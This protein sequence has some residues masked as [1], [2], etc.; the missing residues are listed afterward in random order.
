M[1]WKCEV[2]T[3]INADDDGAICDL[4]G[5]KKGAHDKDPKRRSS[6]KS[7]SSKHQSEKEKHMS[8]RAILRLGPDAFVKEGVFG[9]PLNSPCP[10]VLCDCMAFLRQNA[11]NHEGLFRVPGQQDLVEHLR[12]T[13]EQDDHADVL[14]KAKPEINDVATLLKL[15]FRTL[16]EPLIANESYANMLGAVRRHHG[17]KGEMVRAVAE[18]AMRLPS[19]NRELLGMLLDF[20]RDVAAYSQINKMTPANLAT[21]FAPSLLRAPEGH[22]PQEALMDMSSAIA[23]LNVLIK[24]PIH[25]PMPPAELIR[26]STTFRS[27]SRGPKPA[28]PPRGGAP[29][30]S[31]GGAVGPPPGMGFEARR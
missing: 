9:V 21:C 25:I 10:R 15:F 4:C 28:V 16:P 30:A 7:K 27:R 6:R 5:E 3:L 22:S 18:A 17:S 24:E 23:A 29:G 12:A 31:G 2:C 11:L 26:K 20:L 1:P 14:N 19:P 8:L 13:Y